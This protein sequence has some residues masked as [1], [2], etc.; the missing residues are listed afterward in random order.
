MKDERELDSRLEAGDTSR[1]D[2]YYPV[3]EL[4]WRGGNRRELGL[5]RMRFADLGVLQMAPLVTTRKLT[6]VGLNARAELSL[7][8]AGLAAFDLTFTLT[9]LARYRVGSEIRL[10]FDVT[11]GRGL[12]WDYQ[13][14]IVGAT[15]FADHL[16]WTD[17]EGNPNSRPLYIDGSYSVRHATLR[18]DRQDGFGGVLQA[19]SG[20][21]ADVRAPR[22]VDTVTLEET[23]GNLE[24]DGSQ[25]TVVFPMAWLVGRNGHLILVDPDIGQ[26]GIGG[27]SAALVN[28]YMIGAGHASDATWTMPEDGTVDSVS[29]YDDVNPA[30]TNGLY[31]YGT[32]ALIALTAE[33][34]PGAGAGWKTQATTASPSVSS[35][36]QLLVGNTASGTRKLYYNSVANWGKYKQSY[37]Y[38]AGS[39]PD[40]ATWTATYGRDISAYMTYTAMGGG[41]NRRRRAL[42]MLSDT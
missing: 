35:G 38:S 7:S 13:T 37:T 41:G 27:T 19:G 32:M 33:F 34:T 10:P 40:P 20:K 12:V 29:W 23:W 11:G 42:V 24:F 5:L 18:H 6:L 31:N 2:D 22:I 26:T 30:Q 15:R 21:I 16:E 17:A 1:G 25:L 4:G 3:M 36:V 28:T 14:P 39:L 8:G 9:Q